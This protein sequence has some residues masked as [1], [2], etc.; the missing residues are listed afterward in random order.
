MKCLIKSYESIITYFIEHTL[1]LD[2]STAIDENKEVNVF[3][4]PSSD[5]NI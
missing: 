1:V 3:V 5:N 2:N 4:G